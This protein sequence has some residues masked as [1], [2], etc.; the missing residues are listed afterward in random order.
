MF[1]ISRIARVAFEYKVHGLNA[2]AQAT[3]GKYADGKP[4]YNF[5]V[6]VK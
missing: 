1:L 6:Y 3:G 4:I 5:S 2:T